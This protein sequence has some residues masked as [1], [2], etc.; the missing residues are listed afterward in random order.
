MKRFKFLGFFIALF[1]IKSIFVSMKKLLG[2]LAILF[3]IAPSWGDV[4]TEP[5]YRVGNKYV[6]LNDSGSYYKALMDS[7]TRYQVIEDSLEKIMQ[8]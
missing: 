6:V 7:L 5:V 2:L 4:R 8:V 3:F 1:F